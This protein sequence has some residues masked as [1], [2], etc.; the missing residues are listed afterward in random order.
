MILRALEA[1]QRDLHDLGEK[2]DN[3]GA[4]PVTPAEVQRIQALTAAGRRIADKLKAVNVRT[5]PA[6]AKPKKR[7]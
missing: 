7:T 6:T 2:I 4:L 3:L 1:I 5:P